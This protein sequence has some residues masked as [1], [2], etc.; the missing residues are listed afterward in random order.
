MPVCEYQYAACSH[1]L[2]T[3][4]TFSD[5]PPVDCPS[6]KSPELNKLPSVP[7][8][9]LAGGG[10]YETGLKS[11]AKRNFAGGDNAGGGCGGACAAAE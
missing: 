1:R 8:F 6:C 11:G 3:L 9:C 10:R 2:E 5:A 7:G 4:Q